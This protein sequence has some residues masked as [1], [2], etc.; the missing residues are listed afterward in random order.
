M[1]PFMKTINMNTTRLR[2][3]AVNLNSG[4]LEINA[5]QHTVTKGFRCTNLSCYQVY[6]MN[7]IRH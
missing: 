5:L 6:S 2:N 4:P 7:T 1:H 3:V